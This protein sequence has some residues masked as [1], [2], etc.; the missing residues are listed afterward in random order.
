MTAPARCATAPGS[1][2]LP[3]CRTWMAGQRACGSSSGRSARAG[4]QLR[5]TNIDG[6]RFTCFATDATRDQL[7]DLELQHH[8]RARC[9]DRIRRAN[10]TR[11]RNLPLEG[12]LRTRSGVTSSRWPAGSWPGCR[13]WP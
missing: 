4:A 2:A 5:F 7:A 10:D 9:K 6:H 13:C 12:S 1:R 8:R 3:G 11:L